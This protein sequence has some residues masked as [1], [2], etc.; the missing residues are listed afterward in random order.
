MSDGSD[1]PV[2]VYTACNPHRGADLEALGEPRH[3]AKPDDLELSVTRAFRRFVGFEPSFEAHV[4]TTR[5][6]PRNPYRSLCDSIL[7][8][9]EL[10][11]RSRVTLVIVRLGHQP[12]QIA[13]GLVATLTQGGPRTRSDARECFDRVLE[14]RRHVGA[15]LPRD[16]VSSS[17][18]R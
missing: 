3:R 5:K 13:D 11:D 17:G 6:P 16:P 10:V 7:A 9:L 15:A 8:H 4:T 18:R 2:L 12:K 1:P 14:E